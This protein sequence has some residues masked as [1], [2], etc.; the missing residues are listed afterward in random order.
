MPPKPPEKTDARVVVWFDHPRDCLC[1]ATRVGLEMGE[2]IPP[3]RVVRIPLKLGEGFLDAVM[4]AAVS[5]AIMGEG[6]NDYNKVLYGVQKL[7]D[8]RMIQAIDLAETLR[9]Q[10]RK[11]SGGGVVDRINEMVAVPASEFV[12]LERLREAVV[13]RVK[14]VET[15]GDEMGIVRDL[16]GW[17]EENGFYES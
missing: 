15:D 17:L 11:S 6:D 1:F 2:E 16:D 12:R 10:R 5:A 14:S 3:D 7:L 13:G 4:N 9:E 8:S